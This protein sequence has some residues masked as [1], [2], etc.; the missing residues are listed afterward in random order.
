MPLLMDLAPN[1]EM[2]LQ[3]AQRLPASPQILQQLNELLTD[4]NSG[5]ED[6]AQLLRRDT[7]LASRIIRISNSAAFGT[8]GKVGSIEEAVTRVGYSEIYRLTGLASA[9][10]LAEQNL[11]Y[12]GITGPQLRDNSLFTAFCAEALATRAGSE[13]R[14]AYTT[15]LLRS[16]GK[17][18][19]N[20]LS[21]TGTT[22][23]VQAGCGNLL[24]WEQATFGCGNA[25]V[26]EMVLLA[27]R[28]PATII[29]PILHQFDTTLQKGA[30]ALNATLLHLAGGL[31]HR[32]G[33][34]LV[35]EHECWALPAGA[36]QLVNLNPSLVTEAT[37]D[38]KNAFEAI[39][40]FFDAP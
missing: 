36:L 6:I 20:R 37:E 34:G 1:R 39:K 8:G 4:V 16:T 12:Y 31:A 15:G 24:A 13:P 7:G 19:L 5:L 32:A 35:G 21:T 23:F 3:I 10:H 17:I 26:A 18:V 2:L 9:A 33:Y 27:W 29:Q 30:H 25:E 11:S 22:P 14:V 28:F 40:S 38:A